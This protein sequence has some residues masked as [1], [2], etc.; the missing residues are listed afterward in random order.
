MKNLSEMVESVLTRII[1]L[2][3]YE[4]TFDL[5]ALSAILRRAGCG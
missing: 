5:G 2:L 3:K 4:E 1:G